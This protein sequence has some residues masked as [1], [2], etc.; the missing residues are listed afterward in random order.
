MLKASNDDDKEQLARRLE[1][2]VAAEGAEMAAISDCVK[3]DSL[4]TLILFSNSNIFEATVDLLDRDTGIK[5]FTIKWYK[6][7]VK[8]G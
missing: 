3:D 1:K 8:I 6:R 2:H 4:R 7:V 5:S